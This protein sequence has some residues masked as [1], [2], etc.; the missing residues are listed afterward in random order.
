MANISVCNMTQQLVVMG[1]AKGGGGGTFPKRGARLGYRV[2]LG[3]SSGECTHHPPW[4]YFT[5]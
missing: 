2:I 3:P 1:T 4:Y 5:L